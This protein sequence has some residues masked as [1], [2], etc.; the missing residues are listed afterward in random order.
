MFLKISYNNDHVNK[1]TRKNLFS[2]YHQIGHCSGNKKNKQ[3]KMVDDSNSR[4]IADLCSCSYSDIALSIETQRYVFLHFYFLLLILQIIYSHNYM[5]LQNN[6][7]NLFANNQLRRNE[8]LCKGNTI[9]LSFFY[10]S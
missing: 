7:T 6:I 4:F 5:Y 3:K 2:V 8:S 10:F 1:Q 9:Y